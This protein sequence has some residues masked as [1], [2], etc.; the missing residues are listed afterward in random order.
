[1]GHR[2]IFCGKIH[3]RGFEGVASSASTTGRGL[4]PARPKRGKFRFIPHRAMTNLQ[5]LSVLKRARRVSCDPGPPCILKSRRFSIH[6]VGS[7]CE[8]LEG[9]SAGGFQG[10]RRRLGR[11]HA[12]RGPDACHFVGRGPA[13][14]A[15]SLRLRGRHPGHGS[16][17]RQRQR[18]GPGLRP[19]ISWVRVRPPGRSFRRHDY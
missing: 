2:A 18:R 1:M 4:K 19:V 17:R 6:Q 12:A 14:P 16:E 13:S 10:P 7:K 3:R 9:G 15:D 11:E 5:A 8:R